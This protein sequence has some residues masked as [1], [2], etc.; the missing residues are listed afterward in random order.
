[1]VRLV[2][3][4]VPGLLASRD[5][6]A[7][8]ARAGRAEGFVLVRVSNSVS[9]L[10]DSAKLCDKGPVAQWVNDRTVPAAACG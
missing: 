7:A 2:V 5:E 10:W 9:R 1:M 8:V 3:L 6:V 4:N